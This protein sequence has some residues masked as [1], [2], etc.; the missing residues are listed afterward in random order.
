MAKKSAPR[1]KGRPAAARARRKSAAP[2][3]GPVTLAQARALAKLAVPLPKGGKAALVPASPAS[4]GVER[5]KLEL[6]QEQERRRRIREYKATLTIMKK[7]G[8]K[9][10]GP[11]KKKGGPAPKEPAEAAAGVRRG[12]LVVRLSRCRS[13]A[14]ASSRDWRTSSACRSSTWPRPATKCATCSA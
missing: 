2:P 6:K 11:K 4:V 1:S 7:R 14:A 3:A 12:R 9:G 13:S 10:L 5:R 8:V